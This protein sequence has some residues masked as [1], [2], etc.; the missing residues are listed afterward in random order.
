MKSNKY[1]NFTTLFVVSSLIFYLIILIE[2]LFADGD[3]TL[4]GHRIKTIGFNVLLIESFF[5]IIYKLSVRNKTFASITVAIL[6]CVFT[7][8]LVEWGVGLLMYAQ[9]KQQSAAN[10][11][12]KLEPINYKEGIILDDTLGHKA[13]PNW[14]YVW[15]GKKRLDTLIFV[16][17]QFSRRITPNNSTT[18]GK[19]NKYAVFFG[20]SF[21]YGDGVQ[22]TQTM[23]YY[24]QQY[25]SSYHA[26]NYGFLAYSPLQTLALL[27]T[28]N[29]KGQIP[30]SSG[31]GV[32]TYINDHIDRA[33]PASRWVILQQGRFPNLNKNTLQTDGTYQNEHRIKYEIMNWVGGS[34]IWNY[35]RIN[36][37]K[38]HNDKHY[39]L[40]VDVISESKREFVKQFHHD[41]FYVIIFPGQVITESMKEMFQK[42]N[43]KVYDYSKLFNLEKFMLETDP[44]HPKGI[45][46]EMV[47][48]QF[49][50]DLEREKKL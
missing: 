17:D 6:S 7:L 24:F 23:P 15:I 8:L 11:H 20:C 47:M 43:L 50:K 44:A 48:K 5:F 22:N 12:S 9:P 3:G 25:A 30:D 28:K 36:L 2:F 27:Q 45:A 14:D 18:E 13:K 16:H 4:R 26:Y 31:F 38:T 21:T 40:I 35:F 29:I 39:Q 49:Y 33:I 1:L 34:N 32:F 10:S 46:Y 37:P 19:K 41:K 42:A